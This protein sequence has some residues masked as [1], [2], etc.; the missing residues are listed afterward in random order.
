MTPLQTAQVRAGDI[1]IRLSELGADLELTDETR[2]ELDTLR[3]E[4]Q[5]TERRIAALTIS[6]PAPEPLETRTEDRQLRELE[7]RADIGEVVHTVLNG[8]AVTGAMRELQDEK[9]LRSNE[10]SIRQLMPDLETRAATPAPA[11][12]GQNQAEIVPYVFPMAAASF[13]G[14][15]QPSVAVGEA[16]YPVLTSQLS[17]ET[18][19]E[20]AAGTETTGAFSSDLLTPL[21]LQASYFFSVEDRARFRGMIEA[22]RMNLTEGLQDGFDAAILGGTNGLFTA[23]NLANHNVTAVT[24]FENYKAQLA[25]GR[26]DGRYA[27]SAGDIRILMGSGTYAHASTAYR[28]NGNQADAADAALNVL[29]ADTAGVRVSA[30]VPAV[31]SDRQNAIVRIGMAM[32]AVAPIWENIAIDD[33]VTKAANGQYVL[34]YIMLHA[35]KILRTDGFYKQQTQHA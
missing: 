11:N 2:A 21:R 31:A 12:V 32:D 17:V 19:A 5:D 16:V 26:V 3:R 13:L 30:H 6:D 7:L 25:Y 34:T 33:E 8:G 10:F 15:Q 20:N 14:I 23:T 28:A 1:R 22:L 4:Y 9:G 18:L 24:T 29:M 27:G 35:F